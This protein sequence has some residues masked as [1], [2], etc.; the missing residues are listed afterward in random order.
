MAVASLC[1][2]FCSKLQF[3]SRVSSCI[4]L[5]DSS[6]KTEQLHSQRSTL[7]VCHIWAGPT[8]TSSKVLEH[9][10]TQDNKPKHP[11]NVFIMYLQKVQEQIMKDHPNASRKEVIAIASKKWKDVD[12]EEKSHLAM[13]RKDLFEKYKDD[14]KSYVDNMTPEEMK[15]EDRRK[16][17]KLAKKLKTARR[18]LG[19]PKM[20]ASAFCCYMADQYPQHAREDAVTRVFKKLRDQWNNLSE[21]EQEKYKKQSAQRSEAYKEEIVR[22][23]KEMMEMGRFDVIRKSTLLRLAMGNKSK[24]NQKEV[25]EL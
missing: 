18:E 12:P 23:E 19:M 11:P 4:R 22:W 25:E 9:T 15:L 5:R 14:M 2:S 20:P 6:L 16:Q 13:Q 17:Q 10:S 8:Y 21:S 1:K 3:T 24:K 7:Q